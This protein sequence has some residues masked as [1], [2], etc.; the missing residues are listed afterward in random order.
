MYIYLY[1]YIL[2]GGC[3]IHQLS[4][5]WNSLSNTLPFISNELVLSPTL[6]IQSQG[7]ALDVTSQETEVLLKS[8]FLRSLSLTVTSPSPILLA[9]VHQFCCSLTSL[10][11]CSLEAIPNHS[12]YPELLLIPTLCSYHQSTKIPF[13][14][15]L[16]QL[17]LSL[18]FLKIAILTDM[19]W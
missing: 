15:H 5:Q 13:S 16:H 8:W 18:V 6:V 11:S 9:Q 10:W 4:I 14:L 2:G 12:N 3:L 1:F 17:L 19:R 7:H